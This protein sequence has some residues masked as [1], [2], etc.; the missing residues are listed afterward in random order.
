MS[1]QA[2]AKRP[3]I[4]TR[5]SR[6]LLYEDRA[7]VTRRA[8]LEGIGA[9]LHW[10]MCR[11]IT[12]FVDDRSVQ[13]RVVEGEARVVSARVTRN[14]S[15]EPTLDQEA[16]LEL[17]QADLAAVERMENA[18]RDI[19]RLEARW[20]NNQDFYTQ[21]LSSITE[22]PRADGAPLEQWREAHDA[23]HQDLGALDVARLEAQRA[24]SEAELELANIRARLQ[25]GRALTTRVEAFVEAQL[26]V[27][28]E[29][30]V[31]LEL[32]YRTPCAQWRPE[33]RVCLVRDDDG[34]R[35]EVVTYAT[36]WQRT[37]ERWEDVALAF[38]TARPAQASE[39]PTVEEDVLYSRRKTQEE[40][41]NIVVAARDQTV[42]SARSA[43][44]AVD[45]MPG[46]DDGGEPLVLESKE[47]ATLA[48]DGQPMRVEV[49]RCEHEVEVDCVLMPEMS[50]VAHLRA[51]GVWK[52]AIPLLAGPARI[53]RGSSL[54]GRSRVDFVASGDRLVLGFGPET[55]LRVRRV[56]RTRRDRTAVT[57]TQH[58]ERTVKIYLSNLS[59]EP[60][61]VTVTERIPV[62]EL[63]EVT[64][65][66]TDHADWVHDRGDGF[67][68]RT[69]SVEPRG[70]LTLECV[71][72]LHAKSSVRLPF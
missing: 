64:V 48:S 34:D 38:S 10:V 36:A 70:H 2:L 21:W 14:V 13:V 40:R 15:R 25:Q 6:V 33:H 27:Q 1:E 7:E 19:A 54:L 30:P 23:L 18:R 67:L 58:I 31:E 47:R 69:L 65:E 5:P 37:G 42:D 68:E 20:G 4:T 35:V 57:G 29:G 66:V 22:I 50:S 43:S 11:G 26:E 44:A 16:L 28:E 24:L 46:V 72:T 53:A 62:S 49:H 61:P 52:A 59:G 8:S 12:L 71:H 3:T 60:K 32:V 41:K 63:T 17:E 55:A 51:R 39:A 9:G 45:E 56:V